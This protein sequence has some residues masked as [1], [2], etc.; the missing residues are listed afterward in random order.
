[1]TGVINSILASR[2]VEQQAYR[3][4]RA[5]MSLGEKHGAEALAEAC[6]KALAISRSPSYK[7]VKTAVASAAVGSSDADAAG[8][9]FAYLRGAGFFD[10][11]PRGDE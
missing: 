9:G 7:T 10:S 6:A 3:S 1:M 2:A 11:E 5:L 8:D 4:C